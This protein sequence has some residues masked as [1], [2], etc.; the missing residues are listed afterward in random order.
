MTVQDILSF[1]AKLMIACPIVYVFVIATVNWYFVKK[2]KH[3]VMM[4]LKLCSFIT[5]LKITTTEE[6]DGKIEKSVDAAKPQSKQPL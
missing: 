2:E 6:N 5:S 4:L 1:L 3:E